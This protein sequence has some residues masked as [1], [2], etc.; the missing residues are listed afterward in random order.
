MGESDFFQSV[1]KPHL[2]KFVKQILEWHKHNNRNHLFWRKTN[3]PFFILVSEMMLQKTTVKQVEN[4]VEDFLQEFPTPEKLAFASIDDVRKIIT[5]LGME[6]RRAVRYV[7]WA[8]II[9]EKFGGIIPNSEKELIA[10]PGVGQYIANSVLCLAFGKEAPLVDTNIIR[11]LERVF[12]IKSKKARVRTD[13]KV[14]TF[15][16]TITPPKKAREI[17]LALLDLGALVC[18]AKKPNCQKCPVSNVCI[19]YGRMI[20]T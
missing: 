20:N 8:K 14:W 15:V 18:T 2:I 10:L 6:H 3:N 4:V 1:K 11:V 5:P 12:T 7:E 17:N 19:T 13:K 9:V 16:K